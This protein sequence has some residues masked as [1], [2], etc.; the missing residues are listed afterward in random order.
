MEIATKE[1]FEMH[2]R[3]D[4]VEFITRNILVIVPSSSPL[5]CPYIF[6]GDL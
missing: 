4:K 5:K 1:M 6:C 3:L 2:N